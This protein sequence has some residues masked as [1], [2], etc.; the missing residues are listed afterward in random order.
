MNKQSKIRSQRNPQSAIRNPQSEIHCGRYRLP[1]GERT[2]IMGILNITPDSFSDGGE[3][4]DFER[5]VSYARRLVEEGAD[6]IDIGGESSRPGS[7]P[8]TPSE[9]LNRIM[10]VLKRLVGEIDIPVSVD[11]YKP[12]VA[13]G[14]LEAGASIINDITG[15]RD[16]DMLKVAA[17]SN[18]GVV[19]MHMA[20]T[21]G[22]MQNNPSYSNLIGE[23]CHFLRQAVS[24]AL[25]AGIEA[26]RIVIDPGIGFGK[27]VE[28]NLEILRRLREFRSIGQ[29]VLAGPSRKSFIGHVLDLPVKERWEGTAAAVTTTILHGADI[30][31][32]HDV[33]QMKRVARMTDAILSGH[34]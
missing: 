17:E 9:E 25:E 11:T 2:L 13:G 27:T 14:A 15:L 8:V 7:L 32:V 30:I 34:W 12:E 21:P 28:H 4:L 18:C 29:P 10:P 3:F 26:G 19:I 22:D 1:I 23:L 24:R 33:K 20:G 16:K 31:R 5:A 6:I